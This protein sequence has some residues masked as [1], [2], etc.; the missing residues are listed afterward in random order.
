MTFSIKA[1][2]LPITSLEYGSLST[3]YTLLLKLPVPLREITF[4]NSCDQVVDFSTDSIDVHIRL[5]PNG[6]TTK[7]ITANRA[8]EGG[9]FL[10]KGSTIFVKVKNAVAL[11]GEVWVEGIIGL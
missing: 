10:Q 4:N 1:G 7:D 3:N 2:F 5:Y 11:E 8:K 9:F 6:F